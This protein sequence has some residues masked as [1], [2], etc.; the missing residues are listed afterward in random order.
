MRFFSL[1]SANN[2]ESQERHR[3]SSVSQRNP[4]P[5]QPVPPA[6]LTPSTA[7]PRPQGVSGFVK[8]VSGDP[9]WRI[10]LAHPVP[11]VSDTH[12]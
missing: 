2:Q 5:G 7:P 3:E 6:P 1:E 12:T 9:T 10:L 4:L 8:H 11:R